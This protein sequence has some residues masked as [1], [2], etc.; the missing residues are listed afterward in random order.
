MLY[1]LDA[2]TLINAHRT[3]YALNRVPEFWRWIL[4]HAEAGS[5]K[6]PSEIYAEVEGGTDDLAAWMKNADHKTLLRL[7]DEADLAKVQTVLAKYG[8]PLSEADMIKIGRDPFL[9][10]A[11]VGHADRC[12]V[13]AEVSRPSKQGANRKVPNVCDDCGVLWQSPV[14]FINDLDFTTNWESL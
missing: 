5:V 14:D 10:A 1:L 3:W 7:T 9:I 11:A 12:V 8:D 4:H 2:N 6:V 13:T